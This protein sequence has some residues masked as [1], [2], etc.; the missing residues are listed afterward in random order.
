MLSRISAF[1]EK[2]ISNNEL[3]PSNVN[4]KMHLAAAALLIE[5]AYSDNDIAEV[6]KAKLKELLISQFSLQKS[7]IDELIEL[8]QETVLE[9][10]SS[11]EF[12]RLINKFFEAEQKYQLVESMW[13]IAYVDGDLDRYEE[14][15]IRKL[16]DLLYVSHSD[17]IRAKLQAQAASSIAQQ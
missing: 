17:F 12:T 3:S 7:E 13:V 11:Y 2:K 4:E 5:I 6:E 10:N 1:F 14:S 9:A 16:A 8:A 15:M